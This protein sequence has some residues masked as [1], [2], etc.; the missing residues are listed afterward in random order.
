MS[1]DGAGNPGRCGEDLCVRISYSRGLC[2]ACYE[3]HRRTGFLAHNSLKPKPTALARYE[4]K[5]DRSGG[6]NACHPW[7]AAT[8]ESG[9]GYFRFDGKMHKAHRWRFKQIFG[10][11]SASEEVRHTCDNPPCQN[12]R[13]WLRGSHR[14]NMQDMIRRGRCPD[15]AG[16]RNGRAKLSDD[17]VL[18][19]RSS[20]ESRRAL[21]R[22]YGVSRNLIAMIQ[23]REI[24]KHLT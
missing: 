12:P 8:D 20:S 13:H 4:S 10:P 18:A 9:Y 11:L 24:W 21:T 5:V 1:G 16:E 6:V 2:K 19:I 22:Q 3:R 17:Q 23:R 14:D 15:R 7:T